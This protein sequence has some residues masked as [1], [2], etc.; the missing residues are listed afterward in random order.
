MV[1]NDQRSAMVDTGSSVFIMVSQREYSSSE[2][3]PTTNSTL[4]IFST[5]WI[6]LNMVP[7][8]NVFPAMDIIFL[9]HQRW[10]TTSW[11]IIHPIDG[12]CSTSQQL[13]G[14]LGDMPMVPKDTPSQVICHAAMLPWWVLIQKPNSTRSFM[15][16]PLQWLD[17]SMQS[18]FKWITKGESYGPVPMISCWFVK[19]IGSILLVKSYLWLIQVMI[20]DIWATTRCLTWL[21]HG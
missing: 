3:L 6:V 20:R 11:L 14:A 4:N 1:D 10:S 2:Q 19:P 7:F 17:N 15:D 18:S 5:W 9:T 16:K 13:R 21:T 12:S 8:W